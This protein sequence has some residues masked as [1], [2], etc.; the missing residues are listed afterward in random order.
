MFNFKFLQT[1]VIA[2]TLAFSGAAHATT[3]TYDFGS[4]LTGWSGSA[5]SD[6]ATLTANDTDGSGTWNFMLTLNS[7]FDSFASSAFIGSLGFAFNP[8]ADGRYTTTLI[9]SNIDNATVGFTTAGGFTGFDFQSTF[10]SR[11]SNDS[12][13]DAPSEWISW[14][15]AGLSDKSLSG[16]Y[17]HVQGLGTNGED[18]AKYGTSVSPVP[19]P[20]TYAMM[21]AGLGLMGFAARRRKANNFA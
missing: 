13:L 17:L 10:S 9:D 20:E 3:T 1:A 11:N 6:F 21:L 19:E 15:V 2:A 5:P 7:S 8:D 18:S 14:S 12:R 4:Y 16:L